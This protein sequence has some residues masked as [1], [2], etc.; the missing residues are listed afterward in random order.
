MLYVSDGKT[1]AS[2]HRSFILDAVVQP[3]GRRNWHLAGKNTVAMSANRRKSHTGQM[4][5][6]MSVEKKRI[7]VLGRA[8]DSTI[9]S[10]L[11]AQ[12]NS[13]GEGRVRG[14][15]LS[16]AA[17]LDSI[18]CDFSAHAGRAMRLEVLRAL[19]LRN[20]AMD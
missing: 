11:P 18:F 14:S 20:I 16:S 12:R 19:S 9:P 13:R 6:A 1:I 4:L 10:P 5:R 2:S 8:A 15:K 17:R 3:T 7:P